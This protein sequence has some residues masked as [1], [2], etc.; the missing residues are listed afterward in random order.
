[1]NNIDK[2]GLSAHWS[3]LSDT[4]NIKC[5]LGTGTFG[6]VVK[7]QNRHTGQMVAIK[8][9][10]NSLNDVYQVKKVL[11]EII[12]LRKFNDMKNS[13]FVTKLIDIILPKSIQK[14]V[15]DNSQP[16]QKE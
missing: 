1:M 16:I 5:M 10:E 11:R 8:C 12:I 13:I 3:D 15:D 6:T 4:Y 14:V 2:Y 7:A 9:I